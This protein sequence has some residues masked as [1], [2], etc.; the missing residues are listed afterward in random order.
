MVGET[1]LR[2]LE[3]TWILVRHDEGFA[4]AACSNGWGSYGTNVDRRRLSGSPLSAYGVI[5]VWI[6]GACDRRCPG[7][8]VERVVGWMYID[9][10]TS[11]LP[12]FEDQN[13]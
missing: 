7:S 6:F 13:V 5:L 11:L 10:V 2:T 8:E 4:S 3:P 9:G 12:R 1:A